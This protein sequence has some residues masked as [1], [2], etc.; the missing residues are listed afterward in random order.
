MH[1]NSDREYFWNQSRKLNNIDKIRIFSEVTEYLSCFIKTYKN[2]K[3]DIFYWIIESDLGMLILCV[4]AYSE[5]SWESDVD[6]WRLKPCWTI[7]T[8]LLPSVN[9][10]P[11]WLLCIHW[12][13]EFFRAE[14]SSWSVWSVAHTTG[15]SSHS[16]FFLRTKFYIFL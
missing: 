8:F 5:N 11:S 16:V 3:I 1:Y 15:I 9:S 7:F 13:E 12:F 2:V 6:L 10:G 14:R 4:L